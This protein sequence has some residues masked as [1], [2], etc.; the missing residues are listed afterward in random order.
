MIEPRQ[1][2]DEF[3]GDVR[4]AARSS[5]PFHVWWLGQSGFLVQWEG[6]HLLFDPYL[7]DSLTR[8]YEGT[9]TPH[10]RMTR[11]VIEPGR[12]DF[13]DVATSTH[14]HT[15]HLD[16]ET[17]GPLLEAN[18]TLAL[19]I[20]E[21]NRDFVAERLQID[22]SF[23]IGLDDGVSTSIEGFRVTG[24]PAA[25]EERTRA[26][27]GYVVEFGPWTVYHSGDTIR[28]DGMAEKLVQWRIDVCF[29]PINGRAPERKV[30]GN[31]TGPEA[32]RLARD[33]AAQVVIPCH[34]EMFE[35]N[36]APPEP[37]VEEADHLGQRAVVLAAGERWSCDLEG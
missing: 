30:P 24:V 22:P 15:D 2:G 35:F 29:L 17:L 20:P 25:H 11:R 34:F 36:T 21:A 5:E 19:I 26:Y 31:M 23:P 7:S 6:R 1:S 3:L 18:P 14:N 4:A 10:R 33:I 32:A 12:L 37:F 28:Y 27:L 8:K 9:E 13:I 16:A